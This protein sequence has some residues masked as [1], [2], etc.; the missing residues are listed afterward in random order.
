MRRL[1][2]SVRNY[3]VVAALFLAANW[4]RVGADLSQDR[5]DVPRWNC[6]GGPMPE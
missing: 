4:R 6:T 5:F 2:E 3:I 1:V